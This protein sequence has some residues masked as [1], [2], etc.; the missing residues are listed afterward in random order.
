MGADAS[1]R[2][3]RCAEEV[4]QA[5]LRVLLAVPAARAAAVLPLFAMAVRWDEQ[6]GHV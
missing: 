2:S 1:I 3:P 6:G 5:W 4:G